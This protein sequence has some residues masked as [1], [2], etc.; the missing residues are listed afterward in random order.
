MLLR[1]LVAMFG[2]GLCICVTVAATDRPRAAT[3]AALSQAA[4]TITV[5]GRPF[6][7]VELPSTEAA[8][9][10][11]N[12]EAPNQQPGI[13][14][15]KCANGK[16]RYDH[17]V[18]L[19]PQ[20][21]G[22]ALSRDGK[23]LLIADDSY[24]AFINVSAALQRKPAIAG[25]MKAETGDIEDE[26][27][28]AVFASI[29][30]DGRFGF[31]SEENAATITAIDLQKARLSHYAR[32]AIVGE[33]EVGNAPITSAFSNDGK[34]MYVTTEV[35]RRAYGYPN[36]CRPEGAPPDEKLD[37]PPGA[38]F[39]I[40][41]ATGQ[42]NPSAAVKAKLPDECSPVRLAITPDGRFA[43][44]SNRASGTATLFDLAK[45]DRGEADSKIAN[46]RVGSNPVAIAVT[47]DGRYVLVGITNRF[48]VGGTTS[49]SLT[50]IDAN[51]H[52]VVGTIATGLFPREFSHGV[53]S[54][55]FLSNN[56]SDSVTVYDDGRVSQL[57]QSVK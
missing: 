1:M 3:C 50:V 2:G 54:T 17:L 26:D 22:I 45:L 56:R 43:W 40:D 5:P 55:L 21:T 41:V 37:R 39:S 16:F 6:K 42:T 4:Y 29:S 47:S 57:I 34:T 27:A 31:I 49:G 12:P 19:S 30:P 36:A 15:L 10:S 13:A 48:G 33:I 24:I 23:Q 38:I 9:V 25:S 14:V 53:G 32:S 35:A 11:V 18:A 7:V 51:S 44:V 28:G 20:P 8:F 52:T 46:V